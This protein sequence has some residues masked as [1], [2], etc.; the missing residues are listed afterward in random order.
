MSY[1]TRK[2]D[3]YAKIIAWLQIAGGIFGLYI[4]ATIM[5]NTENVSGALLFIILFG[6]SLPIFSIYCGIRLFGRATRRLGM[7][8]SM[9]NQGLQF[10]Q[11]CIAGTGLSY[12]SGIDLTIGIKAHQLNFGFHVASYFDMSI[13]TDDPSKFCI[14]IFAIAVFIVLLQLYRH[15]KEEELN[16][17]D[18]N[19]YADSAVSE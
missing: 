15:P 13:R 3:L 11:F 16:G 14:N 7:I 9:V 2:S 17:F 6:L 1:F 4:M 5:L 8:V 18:E 10:L 19:Q 12:A